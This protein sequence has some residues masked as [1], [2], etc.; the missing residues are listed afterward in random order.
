[1]SSATNV[2]ADKDSEA[3]QRVAI[4]ALAKRSG[5]TI[6]DWYYDPARERR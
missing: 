2:G 1:M 5:A 6:V 4:D 3:R